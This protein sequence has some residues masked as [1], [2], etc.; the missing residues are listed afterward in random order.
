MTQRPPGRA[1]HRGTRLLALPVLALTLAAL[2]PSGPAPAQPVAAPAA[3]RTVVTAPLQDLPTS[4]SLSERAEDLWTSALG[5]FGFSSGTSYFMRRHG[6]LQRG[7]AA[8][9]DFTWLMDIS[10]Y[11]LKEIE[12]S[13]GLI[14]GFSLTF[15][16][17]RELTEADRDYVERM[18]ERHAQRNNGPLALVQRT[19]VRGILD[20]TEIGGFTVDKVEVDLFPLPKVKF[21]LTPT[22]APVGLEASRILRAIDRLNARVQGMATQRPQGMDLPQT[23]MST[24]LRP[25][26]LE[27]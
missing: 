8:Q 23:P 12:S 11:K 14:P 16:Q 15:G 10:G 1:S 4:G 2:A 18:L 7:R 22:D 27:N 13:V 19:I 6:A 24:P 26:T 9:D 17:A 3:P 25:V 20:A 21:V 5:L